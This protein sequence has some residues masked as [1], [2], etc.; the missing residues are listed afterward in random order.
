MIRTPP[1][2]QTKHPAGQIVN[3]VGVVSPIHQVKDLATEIS[4]FHVNFKKENDDKVRRET[5]PSHGQV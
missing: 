3:P 2:H 4:D 1:Q 5:S